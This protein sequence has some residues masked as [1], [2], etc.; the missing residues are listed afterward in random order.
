MKVKIW[1]F[2]DLTL[3]QKLIYIGNTG[4][5]ALEY[6]PSEKFSNDSMSVEPI[7][8]RELYESTKKIVKGETTQ[9]IKEMFSIDG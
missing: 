3:L 1:R 9:S 5:G 6:E 7:E 2:K 8:I 4:M